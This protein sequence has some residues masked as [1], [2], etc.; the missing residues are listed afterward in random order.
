MI[1]LNLSPAHMT[2]AATILTLYPEMFPGPLGV[3]SSR[4]RALADGKWSLRRRLQIRDFT[5][6]KHRS[7]DDTPAGGGAG[8]GDA[9]AD[10][11]AARSTMRSQAHPAAPDCSR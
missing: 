10:V 7:V 9:C 3:V 2:F 5:T 8:M 6:D 11:L 4:G 1:S